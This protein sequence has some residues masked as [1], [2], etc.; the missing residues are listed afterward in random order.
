MF[1]LVLSLCCVAGAA[2]GVPAIGESWQA[3][4]RAVAQMDWA[5]YYRNQS[6]PGAWPSQPG[7]QWAGP[8]AWQLPTG[9]WISPSM[10]WSQ[11]TGCAGPPA[12]ISPSMRWTAPSPPG[13]AEAP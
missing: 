12:W 7:A 6:C 2:L 4:S 1:Q 5:A 11:P 8:N 10:Q 13:S 3:Y 9:A